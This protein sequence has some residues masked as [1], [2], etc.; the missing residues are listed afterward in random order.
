MQGLVASEPRTDRCQLK[1]RRCHAFIALCCCAPQRIL[2]RRS[3]LPCGDAD[4]MQT[5]D[6]ASHNI[7]GHCFRRKHGRQSKSDRV[8]LRPRPLP[9]SDGLS[10][11]L[12]EPSHSRDCSGDALEIRSRA[13][14]PRAPSHTPTCSPPS[15]ELLRGSGGLGS[16]L[17]A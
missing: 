13:T 2:Q 16:K 14:S 10:S 17:E 1:T 9:C 12:R 4:M 3:G 5:V 15:P 6:Q 7:G 8:G 11:P